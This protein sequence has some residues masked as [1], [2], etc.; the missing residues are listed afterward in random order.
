MPRRLGQHFLRDPAILDRIIE[1][2]DPQPEDAVVEI[3]PGEGTLTRRLAP[4]V[5]QLTAIE[6]DQRLAA[7]LQGVGSGERYPPL[8]GRVTVI[9]ADAL[10]LDWSRAV[11]LPTPHSP[12]KVIGNIPYQITSPLIEKALTPPLPAVIVFLV[13]KEVA[14]RVTAIPGSRAY[15]ALSVGVQVVARA[16]RLFSVKAGAFA[17]PPRVDSAVLRLT[18]L[19]Q[20]L[21]TPT[22][23][24]AFRSFVVGLF[25]QRR[26][27]LVRSL[28]DVAGLDRDAAGQ[29]L[30]H[31][32]L[33]PDA[34]VETVSPEG[35]VRLHR[36]TNAA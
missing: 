24:P 12:W 3:G 9:A 20:P 22:E 18:P 11:P 19:A 6:K 13:Q 36:L 17:P 4:R 1:A 35:L 14:E 32:G 25:G 7:L 30:H 21:V 27:Q 2:L 29:V 23:Q 34:R 16:E 10:D 31:A 5:R 8:G 26:K 28:R 15:G 33:E